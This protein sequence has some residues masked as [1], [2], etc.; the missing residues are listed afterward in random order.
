MTARKH[1]LTLAA[2]SVAA[3]LAACG[4]GGDGATGNTSGGG[5]TP[6]PQTAS[7]PVTVIDGPIQGAVVCL[8]R[9]L[10]GACDAGEPKATTDANGQVTLTIDKGDLN[11]YPV[12][13]FVGVDAVDKDTGKV[14][15]PFVLK[16]PAD[17]PGVVS[18]ITT[19]VQITIENTGTSTGDAAKAV[20]QQ[21]G[22]NASPFADYTQ[23]N[24]ADANNLKRIAQLVVSTTQKQLDV[25]KASEGTKDMNGNSITHQDVQNAV[26]QAVL[27]A[28]PQM[29]GALAD[30]ANEGKS[31]SDIAQGLVNHIGVDPGSIG[32]AVAALHS[33]DA[34]PAGAPKADGQLHTLNYTD[35]NNWNRR[36]LSASQDQATP[37]GG[38]TRYYDRRSR[39]AKGVI[40]NWSF[41]G[42]PT[43]QNDVHWDGQAWVQCKLLQESTATLRDPQG[44]SSYDY[45]DGFEAGASVR[46]TFDLKGKAMKD[47]Y[48]QIVAGGYTNIEIAN[49]DTALGSATFPDGAK[50]YLQSNSSLSTAIA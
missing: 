45:C 40:A 46:S 33:P 21:L 11:K 4:G 24:S 49:A 31:V 19:L 42:D 50:L 32:L 25:L 20:Q 48:Q 14:A 17:Q 1:G 36:V 39:A 23:G 15:V 12:L 47:V 26:A 10:N 37:K 22:V 6:A 44:R 18:P 35:A 5:G 27:Q 28:L 43:R 9:N 30:P 8:D 2:L 16:A 7:L 29:L 34:S 41:S 38:L 13:A 3:L